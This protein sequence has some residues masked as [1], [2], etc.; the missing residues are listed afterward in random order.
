MLAQ[1]SGADEEGGDDYGIKDGRQGSKDSGYYSQRNSKTISAGGSRRDSIITEEIAEMMMKEGVEEDADDKAEE[2][3]DEGATLLLEEEM[4]Q[5]TKKDT[6]IKQS[7]V[8]TPN[9]DDPAPIHHPHR[10]Q[11]STRFISPRKPAEPRLS[12]EEALVAGA[13]HAGDRE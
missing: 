13:R 6:M 12:A 4:D 8:P 5:H 10:T 1:P 2:A 7:T 9:T 3:D 11:I